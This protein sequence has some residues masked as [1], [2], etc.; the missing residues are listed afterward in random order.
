MRR[1]PSL[2]N[3]YDA[4]VVGA[5]CAGAATAMLLARSGLRVLMVERGAYGS[6]TLSTHALMRGAV[7]QLARWGLIDAVR[8]AGTPAVTKAT[9]HY[10][11]EAVA[12]PIRP[13]GGIDALYAPRR[14]VLDRILVDAAVA[15]GAEVRFG[16]T[17]TGLMRGMDGRVTGAV[18]RD[19]AGAAR[20][21]R[22]GL[23]IGA[24]GRS[25][26]AALAGAEVLVEGKAAAAVLFGYFPGLAPG[27]ANDGYHW[28]YRPGA[29]AGA[30]PTNAGETCVFAALPPQALRE[31]A[32]PPEARFRAALARAAPELAES[33]A[34][35]E[36]AGR[37]RLFAGVRGYLRRAVGPGWALVGDAGYFKDPVTA[38]G[39]TDA[40]RD[41]ELLAR[42]VGAGNAQ[43]LEDYQTL[44]DALSLPLFRA[45][46]AIA[47]LDWTLEALKGRLAALNE[48]MQTEVSVLGAVAAR[49]PLPA[50]P[51]G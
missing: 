44:R 19:G 33:L 51:E 49:M 13:G 27:L 42:A 41:A 6:D 34:G 37:L 30:I 36:P 26:V 35:V 3:D 8:A 23:V 1:N 39:I 12:V 31:G 21:L 9:F 11:D 2:R 32:E 20:E 7:M 38:H 24:D 50:P 48:A 46:D 10:G 45:T 14:S 15:A 43:A 17:L 40:L 16:C 25:S 18:L 5:R 22:A 29:T 28:F 47:A 4:V